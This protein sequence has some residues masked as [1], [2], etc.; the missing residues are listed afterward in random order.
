MTDTGVGKG[1]I[2]IVQ[3]NSSDFKVNQVDEDKATPAYSSGIDLKGAFGR[4][5]DT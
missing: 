4:G 1:K 3:Q 5:I 2:S